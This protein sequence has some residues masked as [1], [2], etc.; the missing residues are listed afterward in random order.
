MIVSRL[1]S[2]SIY[3]PGSVLGQGHSIGELA[4]KKSQARTQRAFSFPPS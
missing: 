1:D 3:L 4:L 2:Q